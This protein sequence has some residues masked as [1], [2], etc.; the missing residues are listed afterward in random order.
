MGEASEAVEAV[1]LGEAVVA[2]KDGENGVAEVASECKLIKVIIGND[3]QI[4]KSL[5]F[6]YC[7]FCTNEVDLNR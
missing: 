7:L 5:L 6:F 3:V 4:N 2:S 1:E